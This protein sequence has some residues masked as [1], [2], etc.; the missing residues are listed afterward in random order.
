MSRW[1]NATEHNGKRK[2]GDVIGSE[3]GLLDLIELHSG[4]SQFETTSKRNE[5]KKE[6][7]YKC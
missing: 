4:Y 2:Q 7:I 3:V 1:M 5:I 6:I